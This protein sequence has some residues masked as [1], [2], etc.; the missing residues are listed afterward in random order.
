[1]VCTESYQRRVKGD[2]QPGTG[3]G[4]VWE[5]GIIRQLLYD[6][7]TLSDKFVPV[8]F[9]DGLVEY[10]PTL[11]KG[12]TRYVVDTEDGYEHLL[13]QLSRQPSVVRPV[14]GSM[15]PLPA[16][17]RQWPAD[18]P[19]PPSAAPRAGTETVSVTGA[20]ETGGRGNGANIVTGSD[21]SR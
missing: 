1:M 13:R 16:R 10:V 3:L 11:I 2:E 17:R 12:R 6:A 19:L 7:G 8:L 9:S 14:L 15:R 20:V 5:A 21:N 4:V 18:E